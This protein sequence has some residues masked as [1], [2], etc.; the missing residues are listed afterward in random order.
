MSSCWLSGGQGFEMDIPD[1]KL[2][3][4][5][6]K[7]CGKRDTYYEN[8][9]IPNFQIL[10]ILSERSND[11]RGTAFAPRS[12]LRLLSADARPIVCLHQKAPF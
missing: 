5:R 12:G 4:L 6:R 10:K 3:T 8:L 11:F 9:K 7:L 2:L 1:V